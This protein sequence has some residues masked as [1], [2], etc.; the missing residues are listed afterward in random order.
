MENN[1]LLKKHY[2]EVKQLVPQLTYKKLA[3]MCGINVQT[4][5]RW[6]A[7]DR[8]PKDYVAKMVHDK[9]DEIVDRAKRSVLWNGLEDD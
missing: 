1:E 5:T 7:G 8:N 3:D 2:K 6:M 9:L 4:L